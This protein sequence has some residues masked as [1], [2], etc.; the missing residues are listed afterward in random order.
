MMHLCQFVQNLAISSV[1][2]RQGFFIELYDPDD[3]ENKARVTNRGATICQKAYCDMENQYWD[4]YWIHLVSL[5][6]SIIAPNS[7]S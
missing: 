4:T 1:E 5:F 2:C 6:L 7:V 3:L